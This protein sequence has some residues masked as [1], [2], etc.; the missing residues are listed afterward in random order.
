MID[1]E[2]AAALLRELDELKFIKSID[3][4]TV[5]GRAPKNP[6]TSRATVSTLT[7]AARSQDTVRKL[8]AET[9]Q[10][11][12][13]YVGDV[14][15]KGS[16][17]MGHYYEPMNP[18]VGRNYQSSTLDKI[19]KV[20]PID[21]DR[22]IRMLEELTK[23]LGIP[24]IVALNEAVDKLPYEPYESPKQPY[25]ISDA[26]RTVQGRLFHPSPVEA[27][28]DKSLYGTGVRKASSTLLKSL[29]PILTLLDAIAPNNNIADGTITARD[30]QNRK[31][32]DALLTRLLNKQNK[33]Q[34][35]SYQ[36]L[37]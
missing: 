24:D 15:A 2:A 14:N 27:G 29:S 28:I 19:D 34:R 5:S 6:V 33:Q 17:G 13:L 37:D 9:Q 30:A 20:R 21:V 25:R 12:D 23:M 11:L 36:R 16:M 4:D 10:V 32:I 3:Y 22:R 26:D 7:K 1:E 35:S 8:G 31:D 18:P